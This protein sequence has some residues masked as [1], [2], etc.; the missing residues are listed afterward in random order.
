MVREDQELIDGA[1]AD[2]VALGLR[3]HEAQTSALA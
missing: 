2:F 1:Q 3:W